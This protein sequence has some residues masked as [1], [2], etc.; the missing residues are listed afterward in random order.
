MPPERRDGAR[1]DVLGQV[2]KCSQITGVGPNGKTTAAFL[3]Y[4]AAR[5]CKIF[6]SC[7][8]VRR[9]LEGLAHVEYD[10]I[11]T[12]ASERDCMGATHASCCP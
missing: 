10:D 12:R 3:F 9:V 1:V 8:G 2:A 7:R 6:R 5:F 11:G 4:E